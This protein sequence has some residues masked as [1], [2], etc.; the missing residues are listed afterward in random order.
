M[1]ITL[2]KEAIKQQ[3]S[4]LREFLKE[5]ISQSSA[6]NCIAKIYGFENWNTFKATLD[7]SENLNG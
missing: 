4:I 1:R 3:V 6:Y 7:K 5:P 2:N